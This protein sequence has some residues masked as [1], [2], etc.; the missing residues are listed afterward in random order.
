MTYLY[1]GLGLVIASILVGA[2][3]L[4]LGSTG[5]SG[6]A[7]SLALID[8]SV[9]A[10]TVA[11]A[12]LPARERLIEPFF[13]S[14]RRLAVALSPSGTTERIT[15]MLDRAGNPPLWTVERIMGLKGAVMLLGVALGFLYGGLG[16]RGLLLMAALGA[17]LFHVPDLMLYNGALRRQQETAKG[18]AEALDM[19]TVCVEAGQG[20]SAALLQVARNVEGPI[21]GEFARVLSEIQIGKSRG[22]AFAA[23]GDRVP[24]PQ[25]RNF[26]TAL[27]QADRL[28]LPIATVLR[29]QTST[30]RLVRRQRA[31]EQAQ[32]VTV[33]I[34]FPLVL[35]IFPALFIVI[36]G[37]GAI[38]IMESFS[39][40]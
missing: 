23:L 38:R 33:K 35:C 3:A 36:I 4:V 8:Q 21:S 11:K 40:F 29:E 24:L 16:L 32:K 26:V 7:K 27:V 30:M 25:V 37:P 22:E 14:M 34:I 10:R 2:F 19:L 17:L 5:P 20:F 9:S 1:V 12:D 28:G 13:A 39:R 6:V 15:R 18:L 31:E